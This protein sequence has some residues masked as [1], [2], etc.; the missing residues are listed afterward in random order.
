MA[1]NR[2]SQRPV[3]DIRA[4]AHNSPLTDGVFND[5]TVN[6][7]LL[8]MM[9]MTVSSLGQ[10]VPGATGNV[11]PGLPWKAAVN[12]Q[13]LDHEQYTILDIFGIFI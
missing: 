7:P 12:Q 9:N 3:A 11:P 8:C 10:V 5:L 2:K 6:P 13:W 4:A 1:F